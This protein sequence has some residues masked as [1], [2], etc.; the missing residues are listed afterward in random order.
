MTL[1]AEEIYE[2]A[3]DD[4][5]FASLA[6]RLAELG[7]ARS[8]VLHWRALD[9]AR[10]TEISMSGYFSESDM[11]IYDEL[12]A[13]ADLWGVAASLPSSRNR[14]T[15]MEALVSQGAYEK[16][17][18]YNEWI[19]R[20]GDD[21]FHGLGGTF[22]N[23]SVIFEI[24]LHRGRRQEAFSGEELKRLQPLMRPLLQM[25]T[26]RHRLKFEQSRSS[27][28]SSALDTIGMA[29]FKLS[30]DGRVLHQNE[31]AETLVAAGDCLIVKNHRLQAAS[32]ADQ[33]AL[34]KAISDAALGYEQRAGAIRVRRT[35][36][37]P[38]ICS[39]MPIFVDA[40]RT[41]M[42]IARDPQEKDNSVPTR[43]R[44]IYRLSDAEAE[45]ALAVAAGAS[46]EEIAAKRAT[47]VDTVRSQ[48]KKLAAKMG[49]R[50]QNEVAGLISAL[51]PLHSSKLGRDCSGRGA[52]ESSP[53]LRS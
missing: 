38:M 15:P 26:V 6:S 51:P 4:E 46:M 36:G 49:C 39:I 12:P 35:E 9:H 40:H 27:L 32:V 43:L 42:L 17:I 34:K 16:S 23:N 14:L 41:I 25:A 1:T 5:T 10:E 8:A 2:A 45:V 44:D 19:R 28:L 48:F 22:E 30:C 50:R 21:S 3:T 53:S 11:R 29:I 20:I 13:G 52:Q 37:E 7:N 33:A 31:A 18:I 24:G 47:A